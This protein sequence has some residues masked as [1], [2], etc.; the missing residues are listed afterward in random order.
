MALKK[1]LWYTDL[2]LSTLGAYLGDLLGNRFNPIEF[3]P[4]FSLSVC[5]SLSLSVCVLGSVR[6]YA[7]ARVCECECVRVCV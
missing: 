6:V 5:L 3:P 2:I 7:R 1:Y 4:W